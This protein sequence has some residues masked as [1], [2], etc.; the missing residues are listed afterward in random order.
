MKFEQSEESQKIPE[1]SQELVENFENSVERHSRAVSLF[2]TGLA[3][4]DLNGSDISSVIESPTKTKI[5]T[6]QEETQKNFENGSA[7]FYACA[8]FEE[9]GDG[10]KIQIGIS[11]VF[12]AEG[13]ALEKEMPKNFGARFIAMREK[14]LEE[15]DVSASFFSSSSF[16]GENP[17]SI[18]K[19]YNELE[20]EKKDRYAMLVSNLDIRL[21]V[22]KALKLLG[23][24]ESLQSY[25]TRAQVGEYTAILDAE[26]PRQYNKNFVHE[27]FQ[28]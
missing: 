19:I 26:F 14:E 27:V 16:V 10:K 3:V 24:G 9:D 2:L 4:S 7:R 13:N 21:N 15:T 12:I 8:P 5:I 25:A 28:N 11:T 23:K 6:I 1:A 18:A 20:G 17:C 22:L